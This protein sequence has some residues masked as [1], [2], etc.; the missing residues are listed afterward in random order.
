MSS[1][2]GTGCGCITAFL[3]LAV[4]GLFW[5]AAIG[6]TGL[7]RWA[8]LGVFVVAV[9]IVMGLLNWAVEWVYYDGMTWFYAKRRARQAR[10]R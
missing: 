4:F 3:G 9:V 5:K 2:S 7:G 10:K 6:V 1:G 8:A